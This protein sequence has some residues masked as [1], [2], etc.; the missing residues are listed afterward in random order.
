M[1]FIN[2]YFFIIYLFTLEKPLHTYILDDIFFP[3]LNGE[4]LEKTKWSRIWEKISLLE[5]VN[6]VECA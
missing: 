3:S 1:R 4:N 6:L 5:A 2:F